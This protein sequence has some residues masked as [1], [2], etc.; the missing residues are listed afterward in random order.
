M[1]VDYLDDRKD[2]YVALLVVAGVLVTL[3]GVALI[4]WRAAV[5][6][7]VALAASGTPMVIGDILR[8]VRR[9]ES[10]I[11]LRRTIAN[12]DALS[13]LTDKLLDGDDNAA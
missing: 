12:K 5:L 6:A 2:G 13:I 7:L 11:R 8:T 1:F 10:A 3:G 9:R 4:D